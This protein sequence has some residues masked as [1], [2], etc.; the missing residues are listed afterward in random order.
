[1]SSPNRPL[2][3]DQVAVLLALGEG[4]DVDPGDILYLDPDLGEAALLAEQAGTAEERRR[5]LREWLMNL[6]AHDP[7]R[8]AELRGALNQAAGHRAPA[9][10][11]METTPSGAAA[12]AAGALKQPFV[13]RPATAADLG[14]IDAWLEQDADEDDFGGIRVRKSALED[15]QR[16]GDLTVLAL[17]PGDE[18]I[19]F[20]VWALGFLY[21]FL[22]RLAYRGQGYGRALAEHVIAAARATGSPGLLGL[23]TEDALYFWFHLDFD[24]ALTEDSGNWVCLPFPRHRELPDASVPVTIALSTTVGLA[25]GMEPHETLASRDGAVYRLNDELVVFIDDPDA[26]VTVSIDG[27]VVLSVRPGEGG[28]YGIEVHG[29]EV[30]YVGRG[31]GAAS[32]IDFSGYWIRIYELRLADA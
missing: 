19:A 32:W 31:E 8:A 23:S 29:M 11:A 3:R 16:D 30:L 9:A 7:A 26:S 22:V 2:L 27:K 24:L 25:E 10:Q 13:I 1:M 15:A 18:P 14:L 12:P 4:A 17:P 5:V 20:C 21:T 6:A 28:A